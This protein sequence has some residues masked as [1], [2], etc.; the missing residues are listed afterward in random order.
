MIGTGLFLIGEFL[1]T[2]VVNY[3]TNNEKSRTEI[4]VRIQKKSGFGATTEDVAVR[5]GASQMPS[6]SALPSV[7]SSVELPVFI[8]Q[9][10]GKNGP[11]YCFYLSSD[12]S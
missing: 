8:N 11:A 2:R 6:L 4:G 9:W 7:G 12:F 3:G 1:G 5:V 10:T